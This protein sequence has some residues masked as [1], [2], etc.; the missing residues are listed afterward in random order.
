MR[1]VSPFSAVISRRAQE[2]SLSTKYQRCGAPIIHPL[3]TKVIEEDSDEDQIEEEFQVDEIYQ[4]NANFVRCPPTF[5]KSNDLYPGVNIEDHYE[6]NSREVFQMH[7]Q[8]E[9]RV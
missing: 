2:L 7:A 9:N 4:E 3:D 8:E 6:E 1:K 5:E